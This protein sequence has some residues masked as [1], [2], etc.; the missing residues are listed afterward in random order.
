M[1]AGRIGGSPERGSV[2]C[3]VPIGLGDGCDTS[4]GGFSED[5]SFGSMISSVGSEALS[6]MGEALGDG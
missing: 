2:G 3:V 1:L 4:S 6:R 5:M